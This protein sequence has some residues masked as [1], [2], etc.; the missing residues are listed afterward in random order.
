MYFCV[1]GKRP[2]VSVDRYQM[3]LKHAV[4]S[5]TP[6]IKAGDG[7]YP[8]YLLDCIDWALSIYPKD[9]PQS[10]QELQDGLLGRGRPFKGPQPQIVIPKDDE[11]RAPARKESSFSVTR[12]LVYTVVILAIAGIGTFAAWPQI[13]Q[14][15]PRQALQVENLLQPVTPYYRQ[16]RGK[17][18][19]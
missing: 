4:D 13:K 5:M 8:R 14:R 16:L 7:I 12:F 9:R 1:T 17:L 3:Y 18:G 2:P 10:A 15:F 6:A 11:R 19:L